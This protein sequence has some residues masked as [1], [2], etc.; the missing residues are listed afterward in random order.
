MAVGE[1]DPHT[2]LYT[3]GHEWDGIKEL[4][5]P[6]PRIVKLCYAITFS[7]AVL[8]WVLYP[9]WPLV[10][11][12]TK[13]VLKTSQQQVLQGQ[14]DA[15]VEQRARWSDRIAGADL[16]SLA[17]DPEIGAI[18][19][20]AG[21]TLFDDNC[22]VCHGSAARGGPG[23]P[24]LTDGTWLWGGSPEEIH[25]TLRVGINST[26][27]E[28]RASQML[29][30][31]QDQVL[32]RAEIRQVIAYVR[33]LSGLEAPDPASAEAGAALFVEH[34]ASCHGEAAK[35][36]KTQGAPDLTDDSWIYGGDRETVYTTVF[37]GRQ[38]HMPHWGE[39]LGPVQLKLLALYVH[40]LGGT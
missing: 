23:F 38:G 18:V 2:G 15:G 22:A 17:A 36:D 4:N 33:G 40:G 39:R 28:T 1:R 3:T 35:G 26:H 37:H 30:F 32:V 11:D 29:A 13:G 5:T 8:L 25:E 19:A 16:A 12:Y 20:R 31:G 14:L 6:I 21:K 27:D 10:T 9:A 7:V 24:N 34:C